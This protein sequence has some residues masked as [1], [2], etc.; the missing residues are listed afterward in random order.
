MIGA[1][2]YSLEF[3]LFHPVSLAV[4]LTASA[5]PAMLD[6]EQ[7]RLEALSVALLTGWP[8]LAKL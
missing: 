5:S 1:D 4:A 7:H 2:R 8:I 3:A 6:G